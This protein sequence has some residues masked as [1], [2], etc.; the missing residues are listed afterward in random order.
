M[1]W[2]AFIAMLLGMPT[3]LAG[4]S[5]L[6]SATLFNN[7]GKDIEVGWHADREREATII[8]AGR[9]FT[10]GYAAVT[11]NRKVRLSG[12]GC[13]YLYEVPPE[14]DDYRPDR[15]LGRGI[16]FQVQK[17]FSIE[18]L[19][20]SYAGEGPAPD[21]TVLKREGFPLRPVAKKCG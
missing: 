12:G 4:C 19:P 8:T 10:F 15:K 1:K 2:L 17:D 21:E 13:D 18:L 14:L 16:Q 5:Y 11:D 3:I 6:L 9:F 7:T 20:A